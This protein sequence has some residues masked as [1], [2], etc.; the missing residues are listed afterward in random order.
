MG[1]H[2]HVHSL[3]E[4]TILRGHGRDPVQDRLQPVGLPRA[5]LPLGPELGGALLHRGTFFGAEAVGLLLRILRRHGCSLSTVN[6][7]ARV[8]SF[9]RKAR[10]RQFL[11]LLRS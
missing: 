9:R 10:D 4:R 6:G 1:G 5:L 3:S 8:P 11:A 7:P 2:R